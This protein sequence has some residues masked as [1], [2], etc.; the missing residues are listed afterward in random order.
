LQ[1]GRSITA[2]EVKSGRKRDS[3]AGIDRFTEFYR[4]QRKLLV[5]VDGISLDDFF[6]SPLS[7]WVG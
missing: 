1:Q 6:T 4:P 5:G 2:V 3:L 7:R